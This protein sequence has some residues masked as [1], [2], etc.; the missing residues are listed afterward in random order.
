MRG[1]AEDREKREQKMQIHVLYSLFASGPGDWAETPMGRLPG[2]HGRVVVQVPK[3]VS[4]PV[5]VGRVSERI[6]RTEELDAV[7]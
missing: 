5:L 4:V 7:T 3:R 2:V 6:E 1:S